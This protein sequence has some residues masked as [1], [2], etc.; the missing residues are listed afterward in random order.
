[1]I[2]QETAE[3]RRQLIADQNAAYEESLLMD[4]AKVHVCMYIELN[5]YDGLCMIGCKA[6]F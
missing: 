5:E 4:Q 1:M 6:C 2:V 3:D